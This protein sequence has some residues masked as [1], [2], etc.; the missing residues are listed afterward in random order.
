MLKY[1]DISSI[2]NRATL[3]QLLCVKSYYMK[4]FYAYYCNTQGKPLMV[5]LQ[6]KA[7]DKR[8]AFGQAYEFQQKELKQKTNIKGIRILEVEMMEIEERA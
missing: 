8:A 3:Q 7:A 5:P 6:V 2:N 4:S 1:Y